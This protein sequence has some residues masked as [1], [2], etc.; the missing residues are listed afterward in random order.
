MN[1]VHHL[2]SQFY[3]TILIF[4]FHLHL[5]VTSGFVRSGSRF[6]VSLLSVLHLPLFDLTAVVIFDG[7]FK[8]R[9]FVPLATFFVLGSNILLAF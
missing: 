9:I 8:L 7:E 5:V 3:K 1:A 6:T 2:T 4:L